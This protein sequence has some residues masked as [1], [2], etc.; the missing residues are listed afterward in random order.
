MYQLKFVFT[1]GI[2]SKTV[3][4]MDGAQCDARVHSIIPDKDISAVEV[5][6]RAEESNIYGIRFLDSN[7]NKI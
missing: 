7:N 5:N 6:L 4:S 1:S 2:E 3:N